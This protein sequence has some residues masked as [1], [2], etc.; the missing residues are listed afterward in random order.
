MARKGYR[1][2]YEAKQLLIQQY[3]K[4]N[5]LKLAIG[6]AVDF[7]IL[8]PNSKEIEKFVEV[9]KRNK[10]YYMCSNKDQWIRILQMSKQHN[11]PVELWERKK[12]KKE[13]IVKIIN[14]EELLEKLYHR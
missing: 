13:F 4:N 6:Q 5:V 9:K 8:K 7:I 1:A 2:E 10:K 14:Y 11:I 12:G 3:G